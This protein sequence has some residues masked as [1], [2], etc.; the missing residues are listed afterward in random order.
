RPAEHPVPLV[1][2]RQIAL[3]V[4]ADRE[5][6]VTVDVVQQV[7]AEQDR[8]REMGATDG[9]NDAGLGGRGD[10]GVRTGRRHREA[11]SPGISR[12]DQTNCYTRFTLDWRDPWISND[13]AAACVSFDKPE[14][15][16]KL[17]VPPSAA[18][19]RPVN[20]SL[21]DLVLIVTCLYTGV[22]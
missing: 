4:R 6:R 12:T 16:A 3:D 10:E 9:G 13:R 2:D 15:Q 5:E 14:A 19:S 11:A 1:I 21:G 7:H 20:L 17:I 18:P 22:W 8:Q